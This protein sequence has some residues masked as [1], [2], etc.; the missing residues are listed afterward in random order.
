MD[1]DNQ[2]TPTNPGRQVLQLVVHRSM[3]ELDWLCE[4]LSSKCDKYIGRE[5]DPDE[6]CKRTH[7]HFAIVYRH[8]KQALAKF[9]NSKGIC[10]SDNFGILSVTEKDKKP[11]DFNILSQYIIKGIVNDTIRCNGVTEEFIR[12][13]ALNRIV[14]R[15]DHSTG[16]KGKYDEWTE[17]RKEGCEFFNHYNYSILDVGKFVMRWYWKRDGRLPHAPAY[18]RNAASLY[19]ALVERD[20]PNRCLT[21]AM[22]DLMEKFY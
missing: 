16:A 14:D 2:P 10:G 5:H 12:E 18:K 17:I 19:Y 3:T 8:S 15:Q 13:C 1:E 20:Q 6:G 4:Y 22:E 7:C 11:Y 21:V 9:L